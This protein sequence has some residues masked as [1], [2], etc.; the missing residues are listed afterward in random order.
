MMTKCSQNVPIGLCARQKCGKRVRES[1]LILA[2]L[3]WFP[4]Q[5]SVCKT[6]I[7]VFWSREAGVAGNS[8]STLPTSRFCRAAKGQGI[9]APFHLFTLWLLQTCVTYVLRPEKTTSFIRCITAIHL[10][11]SQRFRQLK[12]PHSTSQDTR[13]T[14]QDQRT[15]V[16]SHSRHS[17]HLVGHRQPAGHLQNKTSF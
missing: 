15:I 17:S 13:R 14:R 9:H 7:T 11:T 10:H 4:T 6:I 3:A 5:P 2:R 1:S 16:S 8:F 12:P